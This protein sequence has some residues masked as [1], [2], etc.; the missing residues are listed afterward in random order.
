[1]IVDQVW[2][3]KE[4]QWETDEHFRLE[5]YDPDL[6]CCDRI[7]LGSVGGSAEYYH[8]RA[9]GSYIFWSAKNGRTVYKHV[10]Q[11]PIL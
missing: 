11:G 2:N 5:C 6:D 8:P 9:M 4:G 10:D 7:R 3:L 1:M